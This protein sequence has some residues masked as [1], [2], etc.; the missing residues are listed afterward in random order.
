MH[1]SNKPIVFDIPI[2]NK[3]R[4]KYAVSVPEAYLIPNEFS[5]I[6]EIMKLHGI[7]CDVLSSS[8]K[9]AVDRYR[10]VNNQFAPRPYEGKQQVKFN[11]LP[12]TEKKTSQGHFRCENQPTNFA[13]DRKSS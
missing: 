3:T 2:Y 4:I 1:Y 8:M 5:Y 9:M 13:R 12:F 7:K 6:I 11:V 10:F